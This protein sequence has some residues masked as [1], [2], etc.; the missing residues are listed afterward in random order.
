MAMIWSSLSIKMLS[1]FKL[2]CV[3]TI[4]ASSPLRGFIFFIICPI[5]E[6]LVRPSSFQPPFLF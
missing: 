1:L 3:K 2:L 4:R 6:M 5:S